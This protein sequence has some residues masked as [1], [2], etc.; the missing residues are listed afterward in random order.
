MADSTP[1]FN[2]GSGKM[3]TARL[4]TGRIGPDLRQKAG[5]QAGRQK[6]RVARPRLPVSAT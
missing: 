4:V 6:A 3:A 1:Q 5:K 2:K